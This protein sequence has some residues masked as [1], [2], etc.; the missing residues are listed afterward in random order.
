MRTMW[1]H[2]A[3]IL[4][5]ALFLV[6]CQVDST[7][8]RELEL[9]I[10]DLTTY[11]RITGSDEPDQVLI[12]VNGGPGLSSHYMT[13]LE[14]LAT[15]NLAVV[16]Y[17]QRGTG[18]TEGPPSV[19]TSFE[20]ADYTADIEALRQE[21]GFDQVH[22]LGHSWGGILAMHYATTYP[23][24]VQSIVLA[25]SGPPTREA[26]EAGQRR[27]TNRL[28]KLQDDGLIL[29]PLPQDPTEQLA[30]MLPAYFA[31]PEFPFLAGEEKIESNGLTNRL[32]WMALGDYDL[33]AEVGQLSVPVLIL[34]GKE[35]PFGLPMSE[36]TQE[37]LTSADV[38]TILLEQC[39]HF[40]QECED[41][42]FEHV[43]DF[44]EE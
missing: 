3:I 11:A 5:A 37:A 28:R 8:T 12:A 6:A 4:L 23:D 29:R 40:W 21:L 16:T 24:Q 38:D 26:V 27:F 9:K 22:L 33:T 31:D 18:R 43:V 13:S 39:G 2:R 30:A 25:G 14:Q 44:L 1:R 17:D 36:A 34:W 7:S 10:G 35:D 19:A 32:T 42:F 20:L 41:E 15:P